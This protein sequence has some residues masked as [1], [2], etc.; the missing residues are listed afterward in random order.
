[1]HILIYT[2]YYKSIIVIMALVNF[3]S[4]ERAHAID[5]VKANIGESTLDQRIHFKKRILT[6]ALDL[7]RGAYGDYEIKIKKYY[8]NSDRSFVELKTGKN[9]NVYFAL[10]R[11]DMESIGTP[12]RIPVRRGL[13]SYRLLLINKGTE[14]LFKNVETL[15]DLKNIR[16]G[17]DT[18]WA[19]YKTVF[20]HNFNVVPVADYDSMFNMLSRKRFDYIPRSINEIFDE[21]DRH[22]SK[23]FKFSIEPSLVLYLPSA[24]YIFVSNKSPRIAQRLHLGLNM[25]VDNGDLEKIFDEFFSDQLIKADLKNRKVI[26]IPNPYLPFK[27]PMKNKKLW[28]SPDGVNL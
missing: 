21:L 3:F 15:D 13:V 24:T 11:K 28:F 14:H 16:V 1:M 6:K 18:A 8:M 10:T 9:I 7:T 5:I 22:S 17:I 20:H 27:T 2:L 23:N 4:F 25:M 12:I 26:Y 19:T